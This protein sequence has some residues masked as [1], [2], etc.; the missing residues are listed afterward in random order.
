[1]EMINNPTDQK[2]LQ[3]PFCGDSNVQVFAYENNRRGVVCESCWTTG[4]IRNSKDEAIAQWNSIDRSLSMVAEFHRAFGHPIEEKFSV[5]SEKVNQL[6]VDLISEENGELDEWLLAAESLSD[7]DQHLD[8]ED[9][10]VKEA[11]TNIFDALLD[12]QVVLDGAFLALGFH[13]YKAAGL[14]EV[15]RSNM[16]K[17]GADGKPIY[18]ADGKILKGPKYSPPDLRKVLGL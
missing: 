4:P 6:R 17:L 18:R 15:H 1:M 10:K 5:T 7:L 14:A 16:S 11:I 3:C 8:M 9:E 12:I 13:R 2:M